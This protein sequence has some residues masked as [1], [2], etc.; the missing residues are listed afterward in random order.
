MLPTATVEHLR[1]LGHDAVS[2][3]GSSPGA[4][5]LSVFELAVN[6][7]RVL[8]TEN[9]ADF[10]AILEQRQA[11]EEPC[12]PVVFVRKAAF[13]RRGALPTRLAQH[14]DRWATANPEPYEGIHWP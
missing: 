10:A 11:L 9:F 6:D 12:V 8:V 4:T 2:V 7:D 14:L 5:D 3:A 13:P 1:Q